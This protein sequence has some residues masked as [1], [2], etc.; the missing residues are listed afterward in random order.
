MIWGDLIQL[1]FWS[2][3]CLFFEAVFSGTEMALVACDKLKLSH[4]AGRGDRRARIALTLAKKPEWFFSTTLLG[5]NLFIVGNS[6]LVTFFIFRHFGM[7]YEWV[8]LLLAPIVLIFGEAVPKSVFQ[9]G[10]DRLG[11]WFSPF[12]LFFSYL[13]SPIVWLLSRLTL[14]LMGGVR[15]TLLGGHPVTPESLELLVKSSEV[16]LNLPV[17]FH[18]TILR[19]LSF[20]K[21]KVY[22]VMTPLAEVFSLWDSLT[23]KEAIVQTSEGGYSH[24]PVFNKKAHNIVGIVGT[25]DLLMA[26][27]LTASVES[28]MQPPLY[29]ANLMGIRDLFY[30]FRERRSN[31]AVVVDEYGGAVGIVT[32]EDLIEEILGAID[33][34]YDQA[35]KQ[36][37]AVSEGN[38]LVKGRMTLDEVNETFSW[39]LPKGHYE[40]LAG[41]LLNRFGRFPGV[42]ETLKFGPLVFT[43]QKGTSRLLDEVMVQ[44]DKGRKV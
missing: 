39:A 22:E 5:Q 23:I 14:L 33:D 3:F 30:L 44:V 9:R 29:V 34:E 21:R 1:C 17:H 13:F 37:T 42:G 11:P 36:W 6:I 12:I 38:Y 31:M 43:V 8:G 16:P 7:E 2:V 40:T 35:E 28:L 32:F 18:K 19:I 4:R 15:G 41:F 20:P 27:K 24:I 26:K 25:F 10:A